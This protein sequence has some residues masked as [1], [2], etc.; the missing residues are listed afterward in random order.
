MKLA[1]TVLLKLKIPPPSTPIQTVGTK[2]TQSSIRYLASSI[3]RPVS[4][5][6][7]SLTFI[8][9]HS[10]CCIH[11]KIAIAAGEPGIPASMYWICSGNI[12]VFMKPILFCH[13]CGS[14]HISSSLI[15]YKRVYNKCVLFIRII[16]SGWGHI[17]RTQECHRNDERMAQRLDQWP[18]DP[19]CWCEWQSVPRP[20]H[21]DPSPA[22]TE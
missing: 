10:A 15:V 12:M 4:C 6:P 20:C 1:S 11:Q 18:S 7:S 14:W 16:S 17:L 5:K 2:E 8:D 9:G 13:A 22:R 3:G 19:W 21:P